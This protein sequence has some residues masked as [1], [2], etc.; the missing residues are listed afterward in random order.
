MLAL[1]LVAAGSASAAAIGGDGW[2]YWDN[3]DEP[4]N[5]TLTQVGDQLQFS[6]TA[7]IDKPGECDQIDAHTVRC[8]MPA[9]VRVDLGLGDDVLN[10]ELPA[11][12]HPSYRPVSYQGYPGDGD[13]VFNGGPSWNNF[14][15]AGNDVYHGGEGFDHVSFGGPAQTVGVAVSLDGVANDGPPGAHANVFPDVEEI[16]GTKYADTFVGS[17]K[18]DEINAYGGDNLIIGRGGADVLGGSG[19][20]DRVFGGEGDD[21]I[22]EAHGTDDPPDEIFCGPGVDTAGLFDDGTDLFGTD[23]ESTPENGVPPDWGHMLGIG[24]DDNAELTAAGLRVKVRCRV[25]ADAWPCRGKVTVRRVD[26]TTGQTIGSAH[27]TARSRRTRTVRV[28]L[29]GAGAADLKRG[30]RVI[31]ILR[32]RDA[33]HRRTGT[34]EEQTVR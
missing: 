10:D 7:T 26:S 18:R 23:C 11:P 3:W 32:A 17:D 21:Y 5:L 16:Y 19:G 6:D 34:A 33:R 1:A 27:F 8:P 12:E 20:S 28:P 25:K 13:D 30:G 24:L 29:T 2:L 22:S 9:E 31:S 14:N 15:V 4:N